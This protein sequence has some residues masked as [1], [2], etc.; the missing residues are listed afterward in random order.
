MIRCILE[1]VVFRI[2]L[3]DE[4]RTVPSHDCAIP[5]QS[6]WSKTLQTDELR[7]V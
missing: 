4:R 7:V 3:G 6:P 5:A 2:I 1:C